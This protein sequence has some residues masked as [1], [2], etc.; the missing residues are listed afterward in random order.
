MVNDLD[1]TGKVALV[2]GGGRGIGKGIADALRERGATVLVN[3]LRAGDDVD[4]PADVGDRDA[5]AAMAEQLRQLHGGLDLLVN[6]A[7]LLRDRSMKKMTG[8]DWDA[9]IRANLTGTFNVTQAFAPLLRPGGRVVNLASVAG[10]LGFFGQ[11]NYAASKAG[12]VALTKVAAKELA[13]SNITVNAVAPG[14]VKTD[15]TAA[16]PGDVVE[17]FSRQIPL[18]RWAEVADVVGAV[19][20]LCGGLAGYVTGQVLHVDGGFYTGGA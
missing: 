17:A 3:D 13:R 14:F 15:M 1:F 9:V 18:G 2:T 8:D 12:V 5:V 6:N 10:T 4:L 20:F 7:G 19:L 11:A 16:M